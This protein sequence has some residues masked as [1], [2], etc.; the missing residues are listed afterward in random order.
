MKQ[1]SGGLENIKGF[2]FS[3]IKCGI[4]Y[5][6]KLDFCL[7][8]SK[9]PCTASGAFTTNKIFA[10]PVGICRERINNKIHAILI[11]STNANACT[12]ETGF[13]TARMLSDAAAKQ[14]GIPS[15]S[16]LLASTGTIGI[17]LPA[18][19][20]KNSIPDLIK[21]SNFKVEYITFFNRTDH[22]IGQIF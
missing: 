1:L 11:N 7:I 2:D 14:L 8:F 4:K 13:S 18:D 9:D 21:A 15:D 17:Q 6:D 19:K 20:M 10:A 3:A 5:A 16:I 22:C 12:G